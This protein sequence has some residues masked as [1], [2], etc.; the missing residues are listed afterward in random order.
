MGCED[1]GVERNEEDE[2]RRVGGVGTV[3]EGRVE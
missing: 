2:K 3:G 1:R